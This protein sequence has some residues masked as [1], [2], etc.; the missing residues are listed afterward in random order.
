MLFPSN[1][2]L[3]LKKQSGIRKRENDGGKGRKSKGSE[4]CRV[5]RCE[6]NGE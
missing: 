2:F 3:A 6:K 5:M 4:G 1:L